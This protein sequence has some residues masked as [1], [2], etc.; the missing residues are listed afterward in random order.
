VETA[1]LGCPGKIPEVSQQ[2]EELLILQ[3][4]EKKGQTV[5]IVLRPPRFKN[6]FDRKCCARGWQSKQIRTF[7]KLLQP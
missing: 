6:P 2:K 5:E 1:A 4:R 3:A 7:L